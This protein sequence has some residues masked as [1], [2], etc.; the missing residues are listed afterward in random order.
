MAGW[1]FLYYKWLRTNSS[2]RFRFWQRDIGII[3]P[4]WLY[5]K[6]R[7]DLQRVVV[8]GMQIPL[9]LLQW[10]TEEPSCARRLYITGKSMQ[11]ICSFEIRTQGG[12]KS[13]LG[14]NRC[15]GQINFWGI[16]KGVL[17]RNLG[18]IDTSASIGFLECKELVKYFHSAVC[19]LF[20]GVPIDLEHHVSG[21]YVIELGIGYGWNSSSIS[22]QTRKA[23]DSSAYP[24]TP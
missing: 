8:M 12:R 14:D 9:S 2:Q 16:P 11:P 5:D 18:E 1:W 17:E 4:S 15:G 22:R 3:S 7:C 6:E 23:V 10:A 19:F 20:K 21:E 24:S 13:L